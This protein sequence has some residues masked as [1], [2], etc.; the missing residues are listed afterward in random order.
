M[1]IL[2]I[3]ARATCYTPVSLSKHGFVRLRTATIE[4]EMSIS[5]SSS[6]SLK[7]KLMRIRFMI[8][9]DRN[10]Q[11]HISLFPMFKVVVCLHYT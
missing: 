4:S 9:P 6:S 1:H 11:R 10:L 7:I 2:P 5:F 3:M 8:T